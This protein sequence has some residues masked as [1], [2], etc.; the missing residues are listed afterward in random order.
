M[1]LVNKIFRFSNIGTILFCILN[2]T[3]IL[4]VFTAGFQDFTYAQWIFILY[5]FGIIIS[6]SPIGEA[7]LV[8]LAGGRKIKRIDMKIR[9]IPLLEIV[10]NKA[11]K[12]NPKMVKSIKLKVVY[13]SMPNAYAI[14]RR[15]LCVTSGLFKLSDEEIMGVLAHELGH[16]SNRDSEIQLII[17]GS[18]LFISVILV[19]I[20]IISW[21]I[22]G[23]CSL[24]AINT[25]NKIAGFFMI[26]FGAISTFCVW[27]WIKVCMLF[28]YMSM[29]ANEYDADKFAFKIGYGNQLAKALDK[30]SVDVP[31]ENGFLKALNSTHPNYNER[32]A[33]LQNLGTEYYA[34]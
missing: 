30:I 4:Y 3:L 32:I 9:I 2:F 1:D 34:Y 26:L 10:Y 20:K 8:L 12:E 5:V 27:A 28:I 23:I 13:D 21:I 17:G 18:N 6:L 22:L 19:F 24:F 14:G 25:R 11:V 7:V 29:R 31:S 15:T 16:F 33:R